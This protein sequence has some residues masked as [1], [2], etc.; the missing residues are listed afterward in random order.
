MLLRRRNSLGEEQLE[1]RSRSE[2]ISSICFR[3]DTLE[4]RLLGNSKTEGEVDD[5]GQ[6][7][8]SGP[9]VLKTVPGP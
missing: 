2:L 4:Y 9:V 6:R 5:V 1:S 3:V 8:L 7:R